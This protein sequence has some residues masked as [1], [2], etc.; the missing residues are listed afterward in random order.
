MVFPEQ[1]LWKD[2][3]VT[4]NILS[5]IEMLNSAQSTIFKVKKNQ[6]RMLMDRGYD[7]GDERYLLDYSLGDFITTYRGLSV[8]EN[9]PFLKTLENIYSNGEEYLNVRYLE[10]P[11]TGEQI[12]KAQIT[13]V[14]AELEQTPEILHIIFIVP[15]KLSPEAEKTFTKLPL[16]RAEYFMYEDLAY[17]PIDSFLVPKHVLMKPEDVDLLLYGGVSPDQ[18]NRRKKLN[19]GNLSRV[20]FA[21]PISRYYGAVPGQIFKIYRKDL[22]GQSMVIDTIAYRAVTDRPLVVAKK[23]KAKP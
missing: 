20:S 16:Y 19:I 22:Y 7:V 1:E 21:D 13:Q 18:P 14:L 17:N 5:S 4:N 12:G 9:I 23:T 2:V 10:K 8:Q 6:I 3:L 11:A 15:N